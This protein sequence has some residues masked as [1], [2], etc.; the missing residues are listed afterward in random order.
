MDIHIESDKPATWW[1]QLSHDP[2]D[3]LSLEDEIELLNLDDSDDQEYDFDDED[4]EEG[5]INPQRFHTLFQ[6]KTPN[7]AFWKSMSY[8][9]EHQHRIRT[10][11]PK[12][13]Q[14]SI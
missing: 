10:I 1:R 9:N 12:G 2:N 3:D 13:L 11:Y 14:T 5:E 7:F 8:Y 6:Q 4:W